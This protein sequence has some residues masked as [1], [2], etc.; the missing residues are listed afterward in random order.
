M[1]DRNGHVTGHTVHYKMDSIISGFIIKII[2][3]IPLLIFCS[4]PSLL[5]YD[6]LRAILTLLRLAFTA[7]ARS[8]GGRGGPRMEG[9]VVAV[10]SSALRAPLPLRV[11]ANLVP[12][13]ICTSRGLKL[14]G[15]RNVA[16]RVR[17]QRSQSGCVGTSLSRRPPSRRRA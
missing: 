17:K 6:V 13:N 5:L 14:Y 9:G 4:Y 12:A 11:Q 16:L 15:H 2:I 3:I 7:I 10:V 8:G 1:F